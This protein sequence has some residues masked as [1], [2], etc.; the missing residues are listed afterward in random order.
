LIRSNYEAP[1]PPPAVTTD[2]NAADVSLISPRMFVRVHNLATRQ[3]LSDHDP[4]L[5]GLATDVSSRFSQY[6]DVYEELRLLREV[7][8]SYV[9]AVQIADRSDNLC[10]RLDQLPLL[11]AERVA[12]S[13]SDYHPSELFLTVVIYNDVIRTSRQAISSSMSGG[14]SIG[15]RQFSAAGAREGRTPLTQL[16]TSWATGTKSLST[17]AYDPATR[18]ISFNLDGPL[19][20][21]LASADDG[22]VIRNEPPAHALPS[23]LS[24]DLA[25]TKSLLAVFGFLCLILL[26]ALRTRRRVRR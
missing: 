24:D 21:R 25:H 14:V 12:T 15:A 2:G 19:S 26:L 6:A 8:R 13:L 10:D 1:P 23:P 20:L 7:F 22:Y 4:D 3:D 18:L 9:V 5:D 11:D 17:E 16:I